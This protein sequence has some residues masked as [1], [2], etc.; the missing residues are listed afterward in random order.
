MSEVH[1]S[2]ISAFEIATKHRIGKLPLGAL[3]LAGIPAEISRNR[4]V[5]LALS[6]EHALAAG[7]FAVPHRDPWDRLLAAQASIEGLTLAMV[8]NEFQQFA[9]PLVR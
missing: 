4:F 8:D 3:I 7:A 1:V 9:I 6:T 2:S 5:E